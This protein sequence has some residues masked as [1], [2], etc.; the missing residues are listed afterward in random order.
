MV[1]PV[2]QSSNRPVGIIN[3]SQQ[4]RDTNG[5]FRA[6]PKSI[7][8]IRE[9]LQ[10]CI[11]TASEEIARPP[12]C[13]HLKDTVVGTLGNFSMFIGKAKQG[14]TFAVTMAVAAAEEN[15]S[16]RNVINM[17]PPPDKG[18]VLL[19]DTEQSRYYLQKVVKRVARLANIA[20]PRNLTTYGL[21]SHPPAERLEMIE[22]QIY[23]TP[24]LGLVVIDG[25]RDLISS[26]N[27][28]EQATMI[29]SKLLKWSQELEIHIIVVLHMNKGD[30]NARGHLGTELQNKAESIF[31]V[32][33]SEH[34]KSIIVI[35]AAC[36]RGKEPAPVAFTVDQYETPSII[37]DWSKETDKAARK[38]QKVLPSGAARETHLE[39]I[40]PLF[41]NKKEYTS[42]DFYHA[43][44]ERLRMWMDV[45]SLSRDKVNEWKS[46]LITNRI[47]LE[48]GTPGTRAVRLSLN[49][50]KAE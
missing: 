11:V 40:R 46:Y 44:S 41:V 49:A 20:E 5:R 16:Y 24:N 15:V 2:L 7:E 33:K 6:K 4:D 30:N 28:E 27:D 39:I 45:G 13:F 42:S 43:L 8:E 37:D 35:E 25:I 36:T 29:S 9:E 19:F 12:A 1:T 14:K 18:K 47:I 21:R 26:I 50:S 38:P 17:C 23:N 31:T 3:A 32:A 10:R 34:D 48:K 22:Y